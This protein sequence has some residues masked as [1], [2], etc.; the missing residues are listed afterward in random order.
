MVVFTT[1]N[2]TR[3]YLQIAEV[4]AGCIE[5]GAFKESEKLRTERDLSAEYSVSRT[6][7]REALL[8]LEIM[9]YVEIRGGAGVFVLPRRNWKSDASGV[10][11]EEV[12]TG[13]HEILDLRRAL[14][15][16]AAYL[17]AEHATED[18]IAKLREVLAT[19]QENASRAT[20]FERADEAFHMAIAEMSNNTLLEEYI[21]DLWTRRRG[22]LWNR[23]YRSTQTAATRRQALEDHQLIFRSIES[24]RPMAAMTAM[25]VHIDKLVARFLDLGVD[26]NSLPNE[27]EG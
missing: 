27:L 15:A 9:G 20:A 4:L 21:S 8:A 7:V 1:K 3:R 25:H 17:A 6:T 13:P 23:W 18:Q 24:H 5:S 2:S 14:E 19:M 10:G 11:D 12:E 26:E 22:A 16:R